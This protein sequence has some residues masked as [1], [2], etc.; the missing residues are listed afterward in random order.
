MLKI[1][2]FFFVGLGIG[3]RAFPF[4]GRYF[5][6]LLHPACVLNWWN[7]RLL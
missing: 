1:I 4:Q 5:T 6:A 7:F 2:D 3:S